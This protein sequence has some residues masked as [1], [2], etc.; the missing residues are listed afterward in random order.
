MMKTVDAKDPGSPVVRERD[1][2]QPR[3]YT[4]SAF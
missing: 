2:H 4:G 3:M 1:T